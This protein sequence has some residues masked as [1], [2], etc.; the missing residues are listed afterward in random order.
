MDS[1]K[2]SKNQKFK[3]EVQIGGICVHHTQTVLDL[4]FKMCCMLENTRYT[5]KIQNRVLAF[6]PLRD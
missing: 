1:G 5:S 2:S 3:C 6:N 4:L